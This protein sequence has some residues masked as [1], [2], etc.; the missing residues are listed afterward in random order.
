[1]ISTVSIKPP[2][3]YDHQNEG[4]KFI[5]KLDFFA[6]F[7]EQGTGKSKVTIMKLQ[8]LLYNRKVDRMVVICP[9]ALKSQWAQEQ[10]KEHF[11]APF[12]VVEW[13]GFD[14]I[15]KKNEFDEVLKFD[16]L[17][18]FVIN[19]ESFQSGTVDLFLKMFCRGKDVFVAIDE[20]TSIKNP[21][22]KRTMRVL[23]GFKGRRYK[24]ILTGT[25]TPNSPFDLYSQFEFL[26]PGFFGGM[27]YHQ[28]KNRYGILINFVDEKSKRRYQKP[29]DEVSFRYMKNFLNKRIANGLTEDDITEC[30]IK[31]N[32]TVKNVT[33]IN[34]MTEY[35]PYKNMEE[36]N[37][38]IE[39]Y[40]YKCMKKDCLDLPDKIFIDLK[41]DLTKEQK[42]LYKTLQKEMVVSYEDDLLEVEH[43]L[44]AVMRL[45][46]IA[47]GLF[48]YKKVSTIKISD[49]L[50]LEYAQ[51]GFEVKRIKENAKLN[52]LLTDL[53]DVSKDTQIIIWCNFIEEIKM[54]TEE[55]RKAGYTA[56]SYFGET[57]NK[58]EVI[59]QY[60]AGEFQILVI[61]TFIGR[62]GL[63]L[64]NCTLH[65][66]YSNTWRADVRL[67]AE[68]RSHRIGQTNKVV[69]KSLICK[70]TID[71]K[72]I[73]VIKRKTNVINFFRDKSL[74]EVMY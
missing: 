18:V 26:K 27:S 10:F 68:D 7:M 13:D 8:S 57:V 45:Q 30:A 17:K 56:K 72:L 38:R 6:L 62:E 63:N 53:Q 3:P 70:N 11:G 55:L 51:K 25:P 73:E 61:N 12:A 44:T 36:L 28:F 1:M 29:I 59:Q 66:F 50:S 47:N 14:T 42:R 48:P 46:M 9:N 24:A 32:T 74:H 40:T 65:Y 23:N 19:V 71:E 43:K 2:A 37:A 54:I 35:T 16:G 21:E 49:E 5:N 34:K 64:Q 60:K 22:A 58:N 39:P 52:A 69:Y 33:L 67:Q 4:L 20:S 15:K 41:I 31:F